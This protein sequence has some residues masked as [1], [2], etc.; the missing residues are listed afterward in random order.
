MHPKH[1]DDAVHKFRYP[2]STSNSTTNNN[3]NTP[4]AATTHAIRSF[5]PS[6]P[7]SP[8]TH[9]RRAPA[10]PTISYSDFLDKE[11]ELESAVH[12]ASLAH[13]TAER[14]REAKKKR[15]DNKRKIAEE[16]KRQ[17]E[18]AERRV[19]ETREEL[20]EYKARLKMLKKMYGGRW[21]G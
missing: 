8:F 10:P 11:S 21:G 3:T 18:V 13:V 6:T 12:R 7:L 15:R 9:P 2:H 1:N 5:D 14:E 4:T 16:A 19:E 20:R 17:Y